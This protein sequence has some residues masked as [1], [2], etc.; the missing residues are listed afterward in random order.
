[1]KKKILFS[2]F[3]F[4][5]VFTTVSA[6][7]SIITEDL[8]ENSNGVLM[9]ETQRDNL[10]QIY[11][12]NFASY[13]DQE[14]FEMLQYRIN[15]VVVESTEIYVQTHTLYDGNNNIISQYE[16]V[17]DP[18]EFYR[19]LYNEETIIQP[20]AH[21]QT[22]ET[23]SKIIN[24]VATY[25]ENDNPRR[26][27]VTSTTTWKKM[28]KVRSYDLSGMYFSTVTEDNEYTNP[29][30]YVMYTSSGSDRV[31]AAYS[32]SVK[33]FDQGWVHSNK[34][35]SGSLSMLKVVQDVT[36]DDFPTSGSIL[37]TVRATY[38]HA[39]KS[40][41]DYTKQNNCITSLGTSGLG[42]VIILNN[43][44]CNPSTFDQMQGV[45]FTFMPTLS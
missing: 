42:E 12:D 32:Q 29:H 8:Y 31:T 20:L 14:T 15:N 33:S 36:L 45:Y 43:S 11:G 21:Y 38:Q 35:P 34:L 39:T 27:Y 1:M 22:W 7:A 41:Y 28:P 13:I 25:H 18:D 4:L 44:V 23:E 6:N 3:A 16:E 2:I 37:Q 5:I 19:D 17:V 24:L 26:Y 40:T 9:T 30:S 10:N